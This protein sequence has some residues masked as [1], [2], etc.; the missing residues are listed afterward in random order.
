MD[1]VIHTFASSINHQVCMISRILFVVTLSGLIQFAYPQK[2][3]KADKIILTNLETHIHYLANDKLEGRRTGTTGEKLASDYI[4][5]EFEKDGLQPDAEN[6]QWL[7]SFDVN[8][9]KQIDSSTFF[10]INGT[11]LKLND[12]FF[13]VTYSACTSAEGSPA[14][15]LQE[16]GVPWFFDLKET[17]EENQNNP[18]FDLDNVIHEKVNDY[19]KKGATAVILYNTSAI[20]DNIAFSPKDKSPIASIPV[21][22]ISNEARKKFLKDE[23]ASLDIK[24]K[25]SLSDKKRVGKEKLIH[26]GA[27]DNASGTAAVIELARM[28]KQAKFKNNNYLFIAFSG[29]EL[30]LFGSKYFTEHPTIQL[31][32]A[33]YMINMDMVGRLNDSSRSLTIGGYGTSPEWGELFTKNDDKKYFNLKYDSSGTGPSDYTS[34]YRKDIPVL[35][36]FTGLHKDYHRPTDESDKINYLGELQIVKYIYRLVEELNDKGKVAFTKTRETQTTTSARFS[37]TLGIM[38]DYTFGGSGVRVDGVSDG[39]PAQ[40]AGLQIGDVIIQLGDYPV[41]SLEN[42]MQALSKFKKGDATKVKY[43]RGNDDAETDVRF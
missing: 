11:A 1:I 7:Q 15:A 25:V 26:H 32:K 28:L 6:N 10:S 12:E 19:A 21:L 42:Y 37:V 35:F 5:A 4:I 2:L 29:E 31:T 33:N 20:E 13:P 43:K 41:S 18:H 27:D 30:G 17:L 38:P 14:I 16:N 34:F 3:K 39:K 36:F 22:Y 9:G 23:S 8:D 24:I 40:K